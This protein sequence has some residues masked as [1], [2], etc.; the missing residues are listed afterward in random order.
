MVIYNIEIREFNGSDY[1]ILYPKTAMNNVDGLSNALSQINTNIQGVS[2]RVSTSEV[3]IT[4]LQNTTSQINTNIQQIN[5]DITSL[6]QGIVNIQNTV[7]TLD[8]NKQ[9][10]LTF[11]ATPTAGS[12]NPVTSNGIRIALNNKQNTLTFDDSP[13]ADSNN[14]VKSNGIKVAL[15]NKQDK[16]TL[17]SLAFK[18]KATLTSGADVTGILPIDNG[19][20]GASTAAGALQNLGVTISNVAISEGSTLASGSIYIYYE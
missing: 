10:K 2:D 18:N 8:A 6:S 17:G 3:K 7:S 9:D 14:P 1:D 12:T 11:D 4:Q 15:D 16:S 13:T 20:T 19:G 5:S